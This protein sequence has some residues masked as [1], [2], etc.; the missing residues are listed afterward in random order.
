MYHNILTSPNASPIEIHV[1]CLNSTVQVYFFLPSQ[2]CSVAYH[3]KPWAVFFFK[4]Q[5]DMG[6]IPR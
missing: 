5:V 3:G 2:P 1:N 4:K 6:L